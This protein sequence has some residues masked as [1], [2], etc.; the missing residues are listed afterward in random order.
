M[1]LKTLLFVPLALAAS[2]CATIQ[3]TRPGEV[4]VVRRQQISFAVGDVNASAARE[5]SKIVASA[6]SRDRLDVDPTATSRVQAITQRLISQTRAFRDDA[7]SWHW[8]VHVIS[9]KQ[10]NAWCMP[11]G[12]IVVYSGL[13]E[14]MRPSDAELAA[15]LGH[16]MAHALRQHTLERM[17]ERIATGL[18]LNVALTALDADERH[19]F[20]A[21]LLV[22][23]MF[24]LPNYREHEREADAIGVELAAR[25]GFSP[26]GAVTLWEKM[27]RAGAGGG[28]EFLSTHPSPGSRIR[29][30]RGFAQRVAHLYEESRPRVAAAPRYE[31]PSTSR[32]DGAI[33]EELAPGNARLTVGTR[34]LATIFVNGERVSSNPLLKYEVPAGRVQLRFVVTDTNGTWTKDRT[35]TLAPGEH[36]NIGRVALVQ[37]PVQT[38]GHAYLTVGTR[39]LAKIVVNGHP[40]GMNPILDYEVPAG[41]VHLRFEVADAGG[42]WV[43]ER[44]IV[45]SDRERR[46]MGRIVLD[47]R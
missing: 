13:I 23:V 37:S 16:E 12:K 47:R 11:G 3:T 24:T 2:A 40:V 21:D 15:L 25:A 45:L 17:S 39:P 19:A 29:N 18:L 28:L 36:R 33:G 42:T 14:R 22:K 34:P 46:N 27:E 35:V 5:Y 41:V 44:T 7:P 6:R 31:G 1:T 43:H 38:A 32:N 10:V 30:L 20:L 4:G 9:D 8:E 26:S